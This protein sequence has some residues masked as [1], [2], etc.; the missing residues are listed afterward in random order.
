VRCAVAVSGEYNATRGEE[1]I[2]WSRRE[3]RAWFRGSARFA[4]LNCRE[5]VN[6]G[7]CKGDFPRDEGQGQH[8]A[9]EVTAATN[10]PKYLAPSF[11]TP[12]GVNLDALSALCLPLL[13]RLLV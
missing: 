2:A 11:A 7:R 8:F 3:H 5:V 6:S 4:D 9:L 13:G 12:Q 10:G 1:G